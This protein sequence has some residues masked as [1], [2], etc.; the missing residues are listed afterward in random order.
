MFG[1][2]VTRHRFRCRQAGP[3]FDAEPMLREC[4]A[5]QVHAML[6]FNVQ[7]RRIKTPRSVPPDGATIRRRA[8]IVV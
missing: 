8:P 4:S 5:F 2:A 3:K 6:C 7:S 1:R